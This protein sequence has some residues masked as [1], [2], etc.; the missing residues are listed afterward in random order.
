M[1]GSRLWVVVVVMVAPAEDHRCDQ[2]SLTGAVG[3]SDT[4]PPPENLMDGYSITAHRT[5]MELL[6][7]GDDGPEFSSARDRES[8]SR[9]NSPLRRTERP[10]QSVSLWSSAEDSQPRAGSHNNYIYNSHVFL[11]LFTG[12]W[13]WI[14]NTHYS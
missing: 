11:T 2:R 6:I 4:D 7:M 10:S 13:W 8:S 14:S 5:H 1:D 3:A 12:S 9:Y